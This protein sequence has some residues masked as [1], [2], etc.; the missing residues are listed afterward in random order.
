[1]N[2]TS[3]ICAFSYWKLCSKKKKKN[4]GKGDKG[5][6]EG[7][8]EELEKKREEAKIMVPGTGGIW[9]NGLR[10]RCQQLRKEESW[11]LKKGQGP[12]ENFVIF[13]VANLNLDTKEK[14]FG[15]EK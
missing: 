10:L 6:K 4:R 7:K 8:K 14:H 5:E 11:A 13:Q 15:D 2:Y 9:A 1:M 12:S 3:D